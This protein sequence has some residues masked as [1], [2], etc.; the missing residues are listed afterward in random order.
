VSSFSMICAC[1]ILDISLSSINRDARLIL[2]FHSD[3]PP[4]QSECDAIDK[5]I[6]WVS[7]SDRPRKLSA[8]GISR[9]LV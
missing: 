2:P 6:N 1:E 7:V 5:S 9:A 8:L 3:L 4:Q